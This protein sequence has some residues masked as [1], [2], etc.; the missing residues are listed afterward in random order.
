MPSTGAQFLTIMEV[1]LKIYIKKN[2]KI[3]GKILTIDLE[4]GTKFQV[5]IQ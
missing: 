1:L 3:I 2:H 5:W 4:Q